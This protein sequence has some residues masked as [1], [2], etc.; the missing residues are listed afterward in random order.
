MTGLS[1]LL[2]YRRLGQQARPYWCHFLGIF[3]L[4][5]LSP[6]LALLAPLPL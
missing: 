2:L 1:N 5:L 4:S 3:L 6:P